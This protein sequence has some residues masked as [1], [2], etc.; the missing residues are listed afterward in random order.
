MMNLVNCQI[1]IYAILNSSER[2]IKQKLGRLLRHK[3]PII[4]IPYFL[5][6]REEELVKTMI[7][8]YNPELISIINDIKD[9]QL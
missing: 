8:D 7:Q 2:L 1:G 5:R 9:I 6:T 4:I 3:Q